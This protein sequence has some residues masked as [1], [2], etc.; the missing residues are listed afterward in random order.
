MNNRSLNDDS[1]QFI[2]QKIA[3]EELETLISELEKLPFKKLDVAQMSQL[4]KSW[5]LEEI[6]VGIDHLR[7]QEKLARKLQSFPSLVGD[8]SGA[9]Q[10]SSERIAKY[11]AQ[12]FQSLNSETIYDLCCGI[13]LDALALAEHQPVIAID[14]SHLRTDFTRWNAS[15][16]S[17]N[18]LQTKTLN[19]EDLTSIPHPFHLDP[20][21]RTEEV[22]KKTVKRSH[23]FDDYRP[24]PDEL[25]K[26]LELQ[27]TAAIKLGP[28]I[29]V[30]DLYDNLAV[31]QD[32]ELEFIEE[33]GELTQAILW[34]GELC[35]MP[36]GRRA[37]LLFEEQSIMA[38]G[39]L[40]LQSTEGTSKE[41][42]WV[43]SKAL[44][45]AGLLEDIFGGKALELWS[46]LGI[47]T[48]DELF[49]TSWAKGYQ[50]IESSTWHLKKIKKILRGLNAGKV[51][52]KTRDRV[53]SPPAI[54]KELKG[55]G[56]QKFTVFVFRL[57]KKIKA[58]VTRE[59]GN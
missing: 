43:P 9:E 56:D 59:I 20:S 17:K 7:A 54:E 44:E 33:Q 58:W 22:G 49:E 12:R 36:G 26:L 24:G 37:T 21:R 42:L 48:S 3:H 6:Q 38:Q 10:A 32:S 57:D 47:L 8:S 16:C 18:S 13:G 35:Q 34:T 29:D 50:V 23:R 15:R 53:V 55:K 41:Y 51:Q 25:A 28:G 2:W 14:N 46:G 27:P 5:S 31:A 45:R 40:P 11:K 19:V 1:T 52:V 30:L 39:G 4:R